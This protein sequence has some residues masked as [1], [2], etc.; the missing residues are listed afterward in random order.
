[1]FTIS[2]LRWELKI[3]LFSIFNK[4]LFSNRIFIGLFNILSWCSNEKTES[5]KKIDACE[6]GNE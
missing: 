6:G 1:M 5:D 4:V 3:E 2:K